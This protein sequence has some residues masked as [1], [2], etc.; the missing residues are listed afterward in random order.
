MISKGTNENIGV[1]LLNCFRN[2]IDKADHRAGRGALLRINGGTFFALAVPAVVT[3]GNLDDLGFG[4]C[5]E[6]FPN[7]FDDD[8]EYIRITETKLTIGAGVSTADTLSFPC[9]IVDCVRE[10]FGVLVKVL[11]RGAQPIEGV[12][13]TAYRALT[14][15][16]FV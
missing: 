1:V 5:P 4:A 16:F 7:I 3:L 8:A 6:L 12:A 10:I 2:G 11:V 15:K 14:A 13:G 9:L